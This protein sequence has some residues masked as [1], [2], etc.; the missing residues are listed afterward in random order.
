M[1]LFLSD[2]LNPAFMI[3]TI[4][5]FLQLLAHLKKRQLFPR[6]LNLL[7]GLWVSTGV[8]PVFLT[9]KG[10]KTP[11]F[12]PFPICQCVGHFIEKRLMT[13]S[14]SDLGRWFES[15]SA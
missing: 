14:A 8:G 12:N 11:D 13:V 5:P 10:T 1:A 2:Q 15:F 9:K 4:H 7:T 6:D 3:S